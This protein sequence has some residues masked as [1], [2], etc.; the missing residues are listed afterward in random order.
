MR[1]QP[2]LQSVAGDAGVATVWRR[3]LRGVMA[4]GACAGARGAQSEA[5][6]RHERVEEEVLV[7]DEVAARVVHRDV[8]AVVGR[9]KGAQKEAGTRGEHR[10]RLRAS[11]APGRSN[12]SREHV[13]GTR[14]GCVA[15]GVGA[16]AAREAAAG[17]AGGTGT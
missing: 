8:L 6:D 11:R 12:V 16:R 1:S 9:V 7:G 15:A 13:I 4:R 17:A 5:R 3:S 2:R 14:G 10:H